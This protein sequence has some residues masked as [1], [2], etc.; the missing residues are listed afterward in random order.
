MA[1]VLRKY[2]LYIGSLRELE[3]IRAQ[4]DATK[5]DGTKPSVDSTTIPAQ[6]KFILLTN[7]HFEAEII[8]PKE[9]KGNKTVS[10]T[11]KIYNPSPDTERRIK[12][13]NVLILKAGYDSDFTLPTIC[14]TVITKSFIKRNGNNRVL[15]LLCSE[16]YDVKSTVIYN[17]V[18]AKTLTYA[19]G[20]TK[21]LDIF[22]QYGIPAGK[23]TFSKT[24]LNKQFGKSYS[25]AGKLSESMEKLCADSGHRWYVI[26]GEIYIQPLD[27]NEVPLVTALVVEQKNVK[28]NMEFLDDITNKNKKQQE[29]KTEGV[30]FTLNLNGNVNKQ[31]YIQVIKTVG[32]NPSTPKFDNF[33][34]AYAV[35]SIKHTLSFEGDAWDTEIET[36]G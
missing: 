16:A 5:L 19:D 24:A 34:G 35:T 22:A 11:F 6:D 23:V 4:S 3:V 33:V 15:H 21:L 9:G 31:D 36:R 17:A 10:Q 12:S 8:Y 20:I 1:S 7:H 27:P 28:G 29:T 26:G 30:K 13:G 25:V 32:K 14:A 18:L 2:E